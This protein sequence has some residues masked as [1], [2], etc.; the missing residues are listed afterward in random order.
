MSR[1][2]AHGCDYIVAGW[3]VLLG[4][5]NLGQNGDVIAASGARAALHGHAP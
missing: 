2:K 3:E 1:K 4:E 5:C